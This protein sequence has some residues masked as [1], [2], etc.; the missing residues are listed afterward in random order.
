MRKAFFLFILVLLLGI[1]SAAIADTECSLAPCSGSV[2]IPDS[3][4]T[5]LTPDNIG[6]HTDLVTAIGKTKEEILSDWEDRGVVFQAWF[7]NKLYDACLEV[8]VRQDEDAR[9]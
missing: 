8:I 4:Y 9:V 2:T 1:C 5:I 7:N 3:K 6:E